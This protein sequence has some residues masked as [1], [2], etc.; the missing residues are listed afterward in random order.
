M[1]H[2]VLPY[3]KSIKNWERINR[4]IKLAPSIYNKYKFYTFLC[5][6]IVHIKL[7]NVAGQPVNL[8]NDIQVFRGK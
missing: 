7:V 4:K 3:Y 2:T 8:V 5:T 1:C 6:Y